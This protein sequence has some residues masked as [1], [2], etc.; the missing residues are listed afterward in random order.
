MQPEGG[1]RNPLACT[2]AGKQRMP[3]TRGRAE[4]GRLGRVSFRLADQDHALAHLAT[5]F[6]DA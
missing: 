3:E 2:S 1:R 5:F 6:C 4:G